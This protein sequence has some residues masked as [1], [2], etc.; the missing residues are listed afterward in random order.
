MSHLDT[1]FKLGAWQ[2]QHDFQA[3]L[4]KLAAPVDPAFQAEINRLAAQDAPITRSSTSRR[5][6]PAFQAQVNRLAMAPG[7]AISRSNAAPTAAQGYS[8]LSQA[9][10]GRF[11]GGPQG[12]AAPQPRATPVNPQP[13][14]TQMN[15]ALTAARPS[16]SFGATAP[17]NAPG[18]AAPTAAP[19][20]GLKT[21]SW[22]RRA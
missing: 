9:A 8:A 6:T 20:A 7:E 2:A 5:V 4:N 14:G 17:T 16:P 1:A 10:A 12:G 3:E 13:T 15:A 18:T 21:P 19:M 22:A 11:G